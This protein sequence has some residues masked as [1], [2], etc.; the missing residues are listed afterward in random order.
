[1]RID[2]LTT[3][4]QQALSDAQSLAVGH[5][6]QYIEPVHVLAALLD[7][8]QGGATGLIARAGGNARALQQALQGA[9]ER[10]PKVEGHGG[11]VQI[12]R[13]TNNLLNLTDKAAQ[14]RGDQFIASELF[15]LALCEDK[16]E[17]GRLLKQHGVTCRAL[18]AAVTQMRGGEQVKQPG[19]GRA[20]GGA[21]E[22]YAGFDRARSGGQAR[23]GDWP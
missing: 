12:S 7:D 8:G 22:I 1:M 21:E 14:K 11:E 18:E 23:P 4:F 17:A 10:L 16:G 19:S 15:L 3:Q 9:M 13:D 20:T 2:K 5:D 6:N